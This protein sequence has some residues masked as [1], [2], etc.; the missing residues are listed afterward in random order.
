MLSDQY[1]KFTLGTVGFKGKV[2]LRHGK[3]EKETSIFTL[4]YRMEKVN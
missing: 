4:N 1:Y 2:D 3:K